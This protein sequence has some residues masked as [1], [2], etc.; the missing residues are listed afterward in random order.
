MAE[1]WSPLNS[2]TQLAKHIGVLSVVLIAAVCGFGCRSEGITEAAA[3]ASTESFNRGIEAFEAGHFA[4]ARTALDAALTGQGGLNADQFV[5]ALLKRSIC[6][7]AAGEFDAAQ[8]DLDNASQGAT[9]IDQLL[10]A[11]AFLLAKQGDQAGADQKLAAAK[12]INPK[13]N[14]PEAK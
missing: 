14:L 13:A 6:L 1:K 8:A 10:I 9:E 2:S 4:A 12:R 11:E 3:L 7:S 5:E